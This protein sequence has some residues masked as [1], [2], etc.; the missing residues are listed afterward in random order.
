MLAF[1]P[2]LIEVDITGHDIHGDDIR[3][4]WQMKVPEQG[5]TAYFRIAPEF[6]DFLKLCHDKHGVIG[7]EYDFD[8]LSLNFGVVVKKGDRDEQGSTTPRN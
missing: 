6:R 1:D 5:G 3:T 2:D 4:L 8:D 7:F